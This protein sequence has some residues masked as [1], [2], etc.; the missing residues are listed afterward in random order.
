MPSLIRRV[1]AVQ[2]CELNASTPPSGFLESRTATILF[3]PRASSTHSNAELRAALDMRI[4][5]AEHTPDTLRSAG[6]GQNP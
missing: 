4:W 5:A 2:R 3:R 6:H 1:K